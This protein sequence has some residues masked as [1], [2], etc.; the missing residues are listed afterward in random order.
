[1][2]AP[3]RLTGTI[4]L[5]M[6][7]RQAETD[8]A[9]AEAAMARIGDATGEDGSLPGRARRRGDPEEMGKWTAEAKAPGGLAHTVELGNVSGGR[10]FSHAS[11]LR[12]DEK[13]QNNRREAAD[14]TN[15]LARPWGQRPRLY[16][17]AIN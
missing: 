12:S 14:G 2:F 10:L 4:D 6:A 9:A 7:G 13:P 15:T 17:T 1:V 8:Y 11:N 3:A 16:S 5:I